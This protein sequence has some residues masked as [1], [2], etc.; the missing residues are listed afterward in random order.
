MG[1]FRKLIT[2]EIKLT[3]EEINKLIRSGEVDGEDLPFLLK[4]I[5]E[6]RLPW[7]TA[8]E[9]FRAIKNFKHFKQP[10]LFKKLFKLSEQ[11][12][13][14]FFSKEVV[15]V[16]FP[17]VKDVKGEI[18]TAYLV[19]LKSSILNFS[20]IDDELL[21]IIRKATG[22]GFAIA[23][24]SPFSQDS[25]MLA[26][27]AGLLTEDKCFLSH[28][29]FTGSVDYYGNILSVGFI[30]EKEKISEE[31]NLKLI[32]A[33]D[34]RN[35]EQLKCYLKRNIPVP[36]PLMIGK[37]K[38]TVKIFLRSFEKETK[39]NCD[40]VSKFSNISLSDMGIV[41][42]NYLENSL[43]TFHKFLE[44]EFSS[45]LL[46]MTR[47]REEAVF[48]IIGVISSLMYGA[49][50]IFGV[51]KK[52]VLYHYQDSKYYPIITIN[53]ELKEIKRSRNWIQTKQ[54]EKGSNKETAITIHIA[55]HNPLGSTRIFVENYLK[56]S[57]HFYITLKEKTGNVPLN[58]EIW[59]T[60]VSEIYSELNRLRSEYMV[61]RFHIFLSIPCP[62]AFALGACAGKFI[63]A[64]I[65]NY[66][67]ER[68]S[69]SP[70]IK[71]DKLENIF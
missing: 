58:Q 44:E 20:K 51:R 23:F 70:V 68:N 18:I 5:K 31:Q 16:K 61:E 8:F 38:E 71:T 2:K 7:S 19:P 41:K 67:P 65:Y 52:A 64:T 6:K 56:N 10:E 9:T 48:H 46:K 55:S 36:F 21:S 28:L 15:K 63:P 42:R 57:S 35:L 17:V 33:E 60:I 37:P 43:E 49:G 4:A 32:T 25:F 39:L 27:A 12:V 69:Y 3:T 29:S 1:W 13:S 11:E 26:V 34:V 62:M 45:K 54:I 59:K 14:N 50:I 47:Q 24:D 40:A 30:G 66:V 53:R 22:K